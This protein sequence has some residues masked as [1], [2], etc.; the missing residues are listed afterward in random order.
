VKS[1]KIR[2][3]G[4]PIFT[5]MGYPKFWKCFFKLHS[6]PNLWPVLV[7]F[8]SAS[9]EDSWQIK[10]KIQEDRIAVKPKSASDYVGQPNNY[11]Y[12]TLIS[13]EVSLYFDKH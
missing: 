7:E 11:M 1:S 2:G 5:G 8:C 12:N 3:F 9:S 13:D 10:K 4:P 6:L